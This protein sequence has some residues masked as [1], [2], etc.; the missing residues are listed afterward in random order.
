MLTPDHIGSRL[1][2]EL[3][4]RLAPGALVI[5][6]AGYPLVF[7]QAPPP[8]HCDIVMVAPHG[9]GRDLEA[10]VEVSGFVAVH[11]DVSGAALARARAYARAIGLDPLYVTTARDEALGDLFGEQALL[12]GGLIGLTSAVADTMVTRGLS[13]ANA[14]F[15]TVAQLRNLSALL[16]SA[17]LEGFWCEISDCAASGMAQAAP[18]LFDAAFRARLQRLWDE[19]E[20]GMFA[21]RFQRSG[22]PPRQPEAWQII[23]RMEAAAKKKGGRR[24]PPRKR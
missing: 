24:R 13:P 10:G 6:A 8:R 11:Q 15:E 23:A 12:C 16:E 17:G 2:S 18:R 14:Y 20:S 22:R 21:R 1:A 9:P 7:P 5:F 3:G 4:P 19:I